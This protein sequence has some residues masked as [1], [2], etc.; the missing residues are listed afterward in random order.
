MRNLV[1]GPHPL[2]LFR[3]PSNSAFVNLLRYGLLYSLIIEACAFVEL[4]AKN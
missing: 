3:I 2:G 4:C 1:V